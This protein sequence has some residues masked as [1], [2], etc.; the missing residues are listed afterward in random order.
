[1]TEEELNNYLEVMRITQEATWGP[2]PEEWPPYKELFKMVKWSR[3]ATRKFTCDE[4]YWNG[5]EDEL[6]R[7]PNPFEPGDVIVA[8]PKCKA[9]G[10]S[11]SLACDEPGC[12]RPVS[13][14][15]PTPG[16]YRQTCGHHMPAP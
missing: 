4:C 10:D 6:L 2:Q 1:M 11:V 9:M 12:W 7:A 3:A 16:G 8:C 15:T 14:G 5:L 13:C